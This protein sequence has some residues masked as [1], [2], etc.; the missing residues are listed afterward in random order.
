[1]RFQAAVE[2]AGAEEIVAGLPQGY[3]SLTRPV[4]C[5]RTELSVG[6]GNE[7]RWRALSSRMRRSLSWM[8]L[9]APSIPGR[10]QIGLTDFR[11]WRLVE[12]QLLLPI[13]SLPLWHADVIHVMESGQIVEYRHH[14]ELLFQNGRYCESWKRQM[15]AGKRLWN[16]ILRTVSALTTAS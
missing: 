5:R 15:N 10:K 13:A 6:N 9:P 2:A 8:N 4:V 1:M 7:L 14:E 3:R 16:S 11:K 12:P